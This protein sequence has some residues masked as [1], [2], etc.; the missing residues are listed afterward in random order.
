MTR[1]RII[2]VSVTAVLVLLASIHVAVHGLP[3]LGSWN[4]HAR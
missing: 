1:T 4:P 3:D 2:V